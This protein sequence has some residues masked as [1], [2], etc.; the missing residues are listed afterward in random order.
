[1]AL[2]GAAVITGEAQAASWVLL[3]RRQVNGGVDVDQINV[4]RGAGVFSRIRLKVTGNDLMIYDLDVRYGNGANDDIPVRLL[5]PQGGQTRA[6]DLRANNR[7][8]RHVRFT[9]GK[10]ANGRGATHVELW[11]YQ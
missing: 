10:F 8:I 9:Y 6:I 5:I 11:G 1:M 2:G 4:G 3:G 7:F